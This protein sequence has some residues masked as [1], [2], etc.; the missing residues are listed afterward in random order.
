[1]TR[2][3]GAA[4][5]ALA[6]S[7]R[8]ACAALVLAACQSGTPTAQEQAVG[9]E[10]REVDPSASPLAAFEP[11]AAALGL[12]IIE[13][14]ENGRVIAGRR[15]PVPPQS[16]A[17]LLFEA[18]YFDEQGGEHPLPVTVRIQDARFAPAP[19]RSLA[20]LD[21]HDQ[22]V[23]WNGQDDEPRRVDGGVFPGFAFAGSGQALAYSK[24]QAPELDA[25]RY[26]LGIRQS[27]RL[28]EVDAPVWGF[29]FSP[30]DSR[31][32]YVD[33]REGFPT[34]MTMAPDGRA[35]AKLTNRTVTAADVHA[36]VPLAPF[37]DGRRPPLWTTRAIFVE[38]STGVHAFD[39]Q[40]RLLLSR[41]GAR[42]LHRGK[43]AGTILFRDKGRTW[44][45]Q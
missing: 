22:L 32:V 11:R 17:R 24:G 13:A 3:V 1:M 5:L 15:L 25:Y 28:T 9:L 39:G 18:R 7:V 12:E 40:G 10:I 34:L 23:L 29:A 44:S 31:L 8:A 4:A 2:S 30:D 19:S 21:E 38:D 16:S 27:V 36:G 41:P 14:A 33:S 45:V 37:P 6:W 26:D 43:A 35:L 20:L 42:D